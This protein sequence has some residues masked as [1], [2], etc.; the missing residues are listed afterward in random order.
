MNIKS[1]HFPF[2][3]SN[4]GSN[5]KWTSMGSFD[6]FV[7]LIFLFLLFLYYTYSNCVINI[8][9]VSSSSPYFSSHL[10][11]KYTFINKAIVYFLLFYPNFFF[12]VLSNL[13]TIIVSL[14][15]F[16]QPLIRE[17]NLQIHIY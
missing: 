5:F 7:R 1:I 15:H 17:E 6:K 13:S 11:I 3:K 16:F 14:F 4:K 2:S 8:D 12:I 10:I 9:K